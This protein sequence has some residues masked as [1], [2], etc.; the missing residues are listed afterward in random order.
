[1]NPSKYSVIT[2]YKG[3]IL[4]FPATLDMQSPAYVQAAGACGASFLGGQH[5]H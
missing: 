4:L 1:V 5:P 2:N 3:A